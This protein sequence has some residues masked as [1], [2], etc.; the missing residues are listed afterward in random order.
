MGKPRLRA[1]ELN[2]FSK[3][4]QILRHNWDLLPGLEAWQLLLRF[5]HGVKPLRAQLG[6]LNT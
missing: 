5:G 4:T 2:N 6:S 1:Q 3:V